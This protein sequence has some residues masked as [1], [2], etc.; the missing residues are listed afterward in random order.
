MTGKTMTG[1][2]MRRKMMGIVLLIA[3]SMLI[4]SA[5]G[6]QQGKVDQQENNQGDA[7]RK[8]KVIL[9]W[10]PNTN[11]TGLYVANKK[12]YYREQ[13]LDVEILEAGEVAPDQMVAAGSADFGVS[14]Q[15]NVSYARAADIPL[16]SIAAVIQHNTSGFASLQKENITRPR[17]LEGKRYA[18]WGSEAEKAIIEAIVTKDGGNPENIKYLDTGY[19]DFLS[20]LGKEVD[21]YWIY[22]GWE[23]MRA[24]LENVPLNVIMLKDFEPALDYYTPVL[25]T[26]E[27]MIAGNPEV[28]EKFLAATSKG[29]QDC[30]NDPEGSAAILLEAAPE[31]DAKLVKASQKWLSGQYQADAPYWGW[32]DT[33]VW[34]NY[35]NWM[36]EKKLLQKEIDTTKAFT[37]EFLSE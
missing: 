5:C 12:G 26:N 27:K 1:K 33:K 13:G 3:F 2:T 37:N 25:I 24:E 10:T 32:Q 34:E 17:D 15:E 36:L 18:Y 21:F 23:G 22:Q 28:V 11:H 7:L 30:M 9:D 8:V 19:V 20:V 4:F 31:L 29:Y 35:A 6:Q 14:F 16:V